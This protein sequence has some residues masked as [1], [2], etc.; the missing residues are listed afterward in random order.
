MLEFNRPWDK[1]P[2]TLQERA[3]GKKEYYA[4]LLPNPKP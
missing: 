2:Q 3:K 1:D 4:P